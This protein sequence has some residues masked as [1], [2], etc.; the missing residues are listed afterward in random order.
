[1]PSDPDSWKTVAVDICEVSEAQRQIDH[2]NNLKNQAVLERIVFFV[3]ATPAVAVIAYLGVTVFYPGFKESWRDFQR[4][5]QRAQYE[6]KIATQEAAS[7]KD[8]RAAYEALVNS[9]SNRG[10]LVSPTTVDFPSGRVAIEDKH[11][12]P[13]GRGFLIRTHF[14]SQN[15]FGATIRSDVT[16]TVVREN[17]EWQ[18]KYEGIESR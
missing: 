15:R 1:M 16:A 7:E 17:G 11:I 9:V 13:A 3:F 2:A 10:D 8:A 5:R 4:N 6:A 14:D 18:V 12:I